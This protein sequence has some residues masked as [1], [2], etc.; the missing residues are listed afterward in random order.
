LQKGDTYVALGS[1]SR[2]DVQ[3]LLSAGTNYPDWV[4]DRYLQLPKDLP[5]RVA[6]ETDRIVEEKRAAGSPYETAKAIE[7]WLREMPYDLAVP[8]PPPGRDAADFLLFD[9]K[10]GYFDYQSTAM[11]VMLRTRDVPCR[12]AVGYALDPSAAD[13]TAYVVKKDNAYTWV[14]VFFPGYGWIAFN[15][16]ADRPSGGAGGLDSVEFGSGEEP[17][18]PD[19]NEIF[20]PEAGGVDIDPDTPAGALQDEPVVNK[21][22]PWTLVL[23]LAGILVAAAAL[24]LS[25][26]IAWNW[27]MGDLEPRA[28]LWAKTQRL[29]G[30]AKLG[31]R[32]AETP[33][34]WSR[35]MGRAIDREG[36]AIQLSNAYEESRYG[37]PDLVRIDDDETDSSYRSVRGALLSKLT[38]RKPKKKV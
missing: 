35:R 11:C 14:E 22:F 19:F 5:G 34:E 38:R 25:G 28:K 17:L 2:A 4:R 9:L 20:E 15:P 16:T 7:G 32:S 12:L 29:A 18:V 30:W 13:S 24:Y 26:R 23:S 21:P 3:Q 27:G 1:K 37:R 31:S 33:R 10:R 8:S 6:D 36:D